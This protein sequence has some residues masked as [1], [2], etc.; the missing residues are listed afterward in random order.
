MTDPAPECLIN[1]TGKSSVSHAGGPGW[2]GGAGRKDRTNGKER[3]RPRNTNYVDLHIQLLKILSLDLIVLSV[4]FLW[5][6]TT[7]QAVLHSPQAS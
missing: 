4:S 1:I 7:P 6:Y 2:G 5:L 3:N